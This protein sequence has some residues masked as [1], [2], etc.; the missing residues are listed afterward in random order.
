[1]SPQENDRRIAR[2]LALDN[3]AILDCAKMAIDRVSNADVKSLAQSIQ[4]AHEQIA[5]E[6]ER[7]QA[8]ASGASPHSDRTKATLTD[9]TPDHS[10]TAVVIQDDG[11]SRNNAVLFR[12]TDFLAVRTEVFGKL[13]DVARREWK[14]LS[15]A[16]CERAFLA[17]Q[18]VAHEAFLA[19]AQAVRGGASDELRSSIDRASANAKRHIERLRQLCDEE[20]RASNQPR[21]AGQ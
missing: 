13:E 2:W 1:M 6:L 17:H 20:R 3:R 5:A 12:P 7:D 19:S 4:S 9:T 11:K 14:G 16:E 18:V 15:E 21:P 10:R 8:A